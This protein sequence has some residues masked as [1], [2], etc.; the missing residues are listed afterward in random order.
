[1]KKH[2]PKVLRVRGKPKKAAV[3]PPENERD[4][5][6]VFGSREKTKRER[7]YD[8]IDRACCRGY[9]FTDDFYGIPIIEL[10]DLE[11]KEDGIYVIRFRCK[12][13]YLHHVYFGR[14]AEDVCSLLRSG[15]HVVNETRREW[16]IPFEECVWVIQV[17]EID[18]EL[19]IWRRIFMPETRTKELAPESK[20]SPK[21]CT[22]ERWD[23]FLQAH[24][25]RTLL[26]VAQELGYSE[27]NLDILG[28]DPNDVNAKKAIYKKHRKL[29]DSFLKDEWNKSLVDGRNVLDYFKDLIASWI[30]ED[31][32]VKALNEYGFTAS[33]ANADSDRVIKTER[34]NVT[35]EPD[36]KIEYEGNTRY[37]ELMDALSPVER[38]GQFD[39]RLSKAKNQFNKKT[40]F[41]LHGLA[42]GKFVL[43]DF[44]RDNVVVT[45]NYPNP[46]FGNKPCSVVRFEDN[47]IAMHDMAI[48]W[49]TIRDVML[50]TK[51]EPEH[52][53]QMVDYAT[54]Q[55]EVLG[56]E[57]DAESYDESSSDETCSSDSTESYESSGEDVQ[58]EEELGVEVRQ[59]EEPTVIEER[60]EE[61]EP[62]VDDTPA[63]PPDEE[64][65]DAS[66]IEEDGNGNVIEYTAEQWEA[67]NDVF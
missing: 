60:S 48:L 59:E 37:L 3:T 61:P 36:I 5:N 51:P 58:P 14:M 42:D 17:G 64:D 7:V 65:E 56:T 39:L 4:R 15:M 46:R 26:S 63:T 40:I 2:A 21:K 23:E 45:Y 38:Y 8:I 24:Y 30:G 44:M 27:Q 13:Q 34:R 31:L 67:L 32:L 41:L 57:Q 47:K 54:G 9:R 33:L 18:A 50:N 66:V 1:M 6:Y 10:K 25:S 29:F 49:E 53:L 20:P 35:G 52:T 43:I 55:I 62:T 28:C 11:E 22:H 19:P 16:G 12:P